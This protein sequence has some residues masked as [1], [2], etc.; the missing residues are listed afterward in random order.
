MAAP[1]RAVGGLTRADDGTARRLVN[2]ATRKASI[3]VPMAA[4]AAAAVARSAHDDKALASA[5]A[6]S[7]GSLGGGGGRTGMVGS[8][9]APVLSQRTP[10]PKQYTK[11]DGHGRLIKTITPPRRASVHRQLPPLRR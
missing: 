3:R 1:P 2:G 7:L 8:K 5:V 10:Q 9:S 6:K 4:S 11:Y